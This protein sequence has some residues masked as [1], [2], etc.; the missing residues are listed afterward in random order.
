M[1]DTSRRLSPKNIAFFS[2][3]LSLPKHKRVAMQTHY[4]NERSGKPDPDKKQSLS[5][6]QSARIP[7][8][9]TPAW[10]P[11]NFFIPQR[12]KNKINYSRSAQQRCRQQTPNCLPTCETVLADQ[13]TKTLG[14]K[15]QFSKEK[16][17]HTKP[18]APLKNYLLKSLL[19]RHQHAHLCSLCARL[20]SLARARALSLARTRATKAPLPPRTQPSATRL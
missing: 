16:N 11:C 20:F 5:E 17:N 13:A 7:K 14:T 15:T 19:R 18:E 2:L 6:N 4:Y 1:N 3:P 12:N 9:P 10:K 8:I